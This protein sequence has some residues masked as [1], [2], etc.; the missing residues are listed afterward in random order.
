MRIICMYLGG[1]DVLRTAVVHPKTHVPKKQQMSG[2]PHHR[3]KPEVLIKDEYHA[4]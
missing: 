2:M 4:H 3:M 1:L